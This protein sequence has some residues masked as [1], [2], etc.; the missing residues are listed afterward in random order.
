MS[1]EGSFDVDQ[2]T[3]NQPELGH[4]VLATVKERI[5]EKPFAVVSTAFIFGMLEKV[6]V[7]EVKSGESE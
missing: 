3:V 7:D 5:A 4:R 1:N 2:T 6:L